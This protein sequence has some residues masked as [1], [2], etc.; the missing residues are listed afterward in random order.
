VSKTKKKIVI[1]FFEM[2]AARFDY[3][4]FL[5][6]HADDIC[7]FDVCQYLLK[8]LNT[9]MDLD[10]GNFLLE[11]IGLLIEKNCKL[12]KCEKSILTHANFKDY[13]YVYPP[14]EEPL[15]NHLLHKYGYNDGILE[16]MTILIQT[17]RINLNSVDKFKINVLMESLIKEL[18]EITKMLLATNQINLL[19]KNKYKQNCLSIIAEGRGTEESK[20]I[21]SKN[22]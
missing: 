22:I 10:L 5:K 8:V 13:S 11:Y 1:Y 16:I 6:K 7:D 14:Y 18:Y 19:H 9:S 20:K 15:L 21:L 12:G 3:K 4:F 2:T 17:N